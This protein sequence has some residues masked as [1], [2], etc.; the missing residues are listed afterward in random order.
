MFVIYMFFLG[1]DLY[2]ICLKNMFNIMFVSEYIV[3]IGCFSDVFGEYSLVRMLSEAPMEKC[4]LGL[5]HSERMVK[6][7]CAVRIA[8]T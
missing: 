3:I 5:S 7:L 8:R 2:E 1:W 4:L 6:R